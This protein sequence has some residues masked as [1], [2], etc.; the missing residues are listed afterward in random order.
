MMGRCEAVSADPGKVVVSLD[1]DE[2]MTNRMGGLHGGCS[3]TLVDCVT[4]LAL[5]STKEGQSPGV[6]VNMNINYVKG[7][8][9]GEK[10]LVDAKALKVGKTLAYLDCEIKNGE[11]GAVLVTGSQT[12]FIG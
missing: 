9:L 11:T 3:A 10:I 2:N 12:K 7:A 8:K 6:S 4:T 5:M 1:I